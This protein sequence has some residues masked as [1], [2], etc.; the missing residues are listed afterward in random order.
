MKPIGTPRPCR[1]NDR[2]L[3]LRGV[4]LQVDALVEEIMTVTGWT[5]LEVATRLGCSERALEK[6]RT[7]DAEPGAARVA[8]IEMLAAEVGAKRKVG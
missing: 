8:G 5:Q 7:G 6:W 2:A 3:L 1:P 4:A